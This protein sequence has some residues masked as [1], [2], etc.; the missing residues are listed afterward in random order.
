MKG[1]TYQLFLVIGP[2]VLWI[3]LTLSDY[4]SLLKKGNKDKYELI[5]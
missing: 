1:R 2:V 3:D 5:L 4:F